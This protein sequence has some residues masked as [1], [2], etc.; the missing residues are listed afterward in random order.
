MKKYLSLTILIVFI[1]SFNSCKKDVKKEEIKEKNYSIVPETT[2]IGWIAY[3]TTDKIPVSG[4]FTSLKII[5]SN[6]GK[7]VLESLNGTEFSIPVSSIFSG[8]DERDGK[9]KEFFFGVMD[10]TINLTGTISMKD[11][12]SGTIELNMNGITYQFPITCFIDGQ[13]VSIEGV[14]NLENWNLLPA[15]ESLNKVCFDQH[16]AQDGISKTWSE[17]KI[18]ANTYLKVK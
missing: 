12:T 2:S 8:N 15:I 6:V 16:K 10:N 7:S 17:V 4:K 3:K 9:L 18:E 14:L 5:K 1:F 13:M 11:D